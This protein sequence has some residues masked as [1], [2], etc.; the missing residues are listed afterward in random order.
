MSTW[1]P[2]K[3]S[4]GFSE[5]MCGICTFFIWKGLTKWCKKHDREIKKWGAHC[6]DFD[7]FDEK[8]LPGK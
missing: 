1:E 2:K 6:V 7:K 3:K 4:K 8:R 5:K